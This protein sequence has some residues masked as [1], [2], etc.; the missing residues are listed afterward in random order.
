MEFRGGVSD[1]VWRGSQLQRDDPSG[2]EPRLRADDILPGAVRCVDGDGS[3]FYQ[4]TLVRRGDPNQGLVIQSRASDAHQFGTVLFEGTTKQE[5]RI[6]FVSGI[7]R[8]DYRKDPSNPTMELLDPQGRPAEPDTDKG[9]PGK[10]EV[11]PRAKALKP[12][13]LSGLLRLL[14]FPPKARGDRPE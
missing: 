5:L 8:I 7:Y 14:R 10:E 1:R 2:N 9:E 12:S 11:E 13:R 6:H 3:T 4:G